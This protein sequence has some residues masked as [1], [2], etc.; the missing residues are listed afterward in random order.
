MF[1]ESLVESTPLLRT[2]NRW[3]AL[4]SFATQAAFVLAL[5]AIPMLHPEIV[6]LHTPRLSFLALPPHPTPPPPPPERIHITSTTANAL[7][8]PAAPAM[9]TTH[10]LPS[11]NAT[12]DEAPNFNP[13]GIATGESSNPFASSLPF[14][15]SAPS[16]RIASEPAHSGTTSGR[17]NISKGVS[18]GLL[19]TPIKPVY[20]PIARAAHLGGTVIVQAVIS[21]SGQIESAH[22]LSG[23]AML[24]SSAL[25]AVRN[26][27]YRPYLLNGEP[28][29]VETTF[30]INFLLGS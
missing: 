20:P 25:E 1:E 18:A 16:V 8:A 29:E 24:Q 22:V 26:A 12:P 7:P 30:S 13:I 6:Q 11:R 14:G 21:K 17:L 4:I 3:P 10:L 19:L 5:I 15:P 27:R 2:H 9:S 28:T 23:P